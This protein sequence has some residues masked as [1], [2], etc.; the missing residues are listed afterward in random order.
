VEIGILRL[1]DLSLHVLFVDSGHVVE[2]DSLSVGSVWQVGASYGQA[3]RK[4]VVVAGSC[5]WLQDRT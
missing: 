1:Q 5:T 3:V 2:H 4:S